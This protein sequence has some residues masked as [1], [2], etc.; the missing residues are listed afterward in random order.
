[1]GNA[2]LKTLCEMFIAD[3]NS[4]AQYLSEH[5]L[6]IA[7][8]QQAQQVRNEALAAFEG[9]LDSFRAGT[10][11]TETLDSAL[12]HYLVSSTRCRAARHEQLQ[13]CDLACQQ[14]TFHQSEEYKTS[15]RQLGEIIQRMVAQVALNPETQALID[16]NETLQHRCATAK[17]APGSFC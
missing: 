1:M 12:E 3:E 6:A 17:S 8:Y 4:V 13:A 5:E 10:S 16:S 7:R 15:H 14:M 9:E 2:A 11:S